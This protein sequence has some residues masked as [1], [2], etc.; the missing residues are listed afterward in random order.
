MIALILIGAARYLA[1][2]IYWFELDNLLI[3]TAIL[4]I[5]KGLMH[6]IA[7]ERFFLLSLLTIFLTLYMPITQ[8]ILFYA[9]AFF[10]LRGLRFI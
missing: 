2:P 8:V 4:L 10:A 6:T 9:V 7:H 1:W 5:T 3:V